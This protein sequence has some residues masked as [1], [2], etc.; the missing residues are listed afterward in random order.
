M[1][2]AIA[3]VTRGIVVDTKDPMRQGRVRVRIPS[4]GDTRGEWARI[5]VSACCAHGVVSRPELEDEVLVVF[6]HGDVRQPYVIGS[7]WNGSDKPPEHRATP[8]KV[9]LPTGGTLPAFLSQGASGDCAAASSLL[10]QA[11]PLLAS[12]ECEVKILKLLK[13]LIDVI[14]NLPSPP[15]AAVQAFA[16]AAVDLA[17]CLLVPT[18]ASMIPFVRD[19]LCLVQHS[20]K[21]LLEQAQSQPVA[22]DATA[23]L[24]A[25]L[26]LAGPF[27]VLAGVSLVQLSLPTTVQSL[28]NDIATLQAVTDA[29]GGCTGS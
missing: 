7:L 8:P 3:G 24:Q 16:K 9:H 20:L 13:P 11:A 17:P 12:M 26:N 15:A 23:P 4:L 25:I 28:R 21:C 1:A 22:T 14:A 19:L 29:L 6:E 5:T 27:F 2:D 10:Q 18:P